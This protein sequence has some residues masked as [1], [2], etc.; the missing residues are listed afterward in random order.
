MGEKQL[1]DK[2]DVIF[3]FGAG[4]SVDAGIPDTYTF[5]KDFEDYIKSEYMQLYP[6]LLKIIERRELFNKKDNDLKPQVDVE[7]L[8]DTL[9]RL[10]NKDKEP[11]LDFYDEKKFCPM[12]DVNACLELKNILEIFIRKK[13]IVRD[14]KM[15][16]YL[17]ELL[18]FDAPLEIYSTNYD[19]CIEQLSYLTF[20]RYTDGFNIDWSEKNFEEYFD[21]K[22]YK[23]HGSVIWVMT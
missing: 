12:L 21:I 3:F 19:T 22:H 5:A 9:R 18:K 23:L 7:Q 4:A 2:Q 8:L 17:K 13:V 10:T 14:S 16:D 1:T 6:A 15:L 20:R 11:L